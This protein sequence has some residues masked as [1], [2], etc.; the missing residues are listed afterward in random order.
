MKV[1][2]GLTQQDSPHVERIVTCLESKGLEIEQLTLQS[3]DSLV[4]H[5]RGRLYSLDRV[6]VAIS[7]DSILSNWVRQDI[8]GGALIELIQSKGMDDEM[9]VP[10]LVRSCEVPL[11]L[12][13]RISV[14]FANKSFEEACQELQHCILGAEAEDSDRPANRVFRTW[15]VDPV[16]A[17]KYALVM[18][19]GVSMRRSEGLHI[20]VDLGAE[21]TNTKDWFGPPN[22]PKIPTRPG[23]PFFNSS[24]RREPPVYVR[25]FCEPEVTPS[26][27]YYLYVEAN[28]P[29]QARERLFLDAHGREI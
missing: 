23:G 4:A 19:F 25:K 17:G 7:P 26:K 1:L 21:Y 15:E 11:L 24:L 27:S 28:E 12:R 14:N 13:D 18:E 2:I 8:T 29:L 6:L 3:D 22:L 10:V 20:E 16:G 9:I 5:I